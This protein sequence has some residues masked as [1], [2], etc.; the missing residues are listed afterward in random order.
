MWGV[1]VVAAAGAGIAVY[2]VTRPK[3]SATL[4]VTVTAPTATAKPIVTQMVTAQRPQ[5]ITNAI[6]AFGTPNLG[7]PVGPIVTVAPG[8]MAASVSVGQNLT[9]VLPSGAQKWLVIGYGAAGATGT[10]VNP[11]GQVTLG[12]DV[13]SPVTLSF[14]QLGGSSQAVAAWV[15]SSGKQ[16]TTLINLTLPKTVALHL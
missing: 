2:E 1:G 3:P 14:E 11:T 5:P 16:Q 15:D 4:P 8:T 13:T 7:L 12:S 9:L 10:I 6:Q